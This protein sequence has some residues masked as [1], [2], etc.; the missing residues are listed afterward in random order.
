MPFLTLTGG[1][2]HFRTKYKKITIFV[3]F[4][5]LTQINFPS[6]QKKRD[7]K[8]NSIG[9]Y[10]I[11]N[12]KASANFTV[13]WKLTVRELE[14]S[15]LLFI[16]IYNILSELGAHEPTDVIKS[17]YHQA[18]VVFAVIFHFSN[19][20]VNTCHLH[21]IRLLAQ[22]AQYTTPYILSQLDLFHSFIC[23]KMHCSSSSDSCRLS[24][25]RFR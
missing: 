1:L 4:C 6:E 21:I 12:F 15:V 20:D 23:R 5:L 7:Q 3:L 9:S 2:P 25:N 17:T 22:N 11:L 13:K 19:R 14:K 8:L 18:K 16:P 10:I 24:K